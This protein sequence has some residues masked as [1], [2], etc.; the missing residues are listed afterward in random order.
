M[1]VAPHA[2]QA[3]A[4]PPCDISKRY[5]RICKRQDDFVMFEFSIGWEE[6]MVELMLP[7]H[8]FEAFCAANNVIVLPTRDDDPQGD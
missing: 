2:Q 1:A 8:A 6:L 4:L 5:V 3:T 7:P